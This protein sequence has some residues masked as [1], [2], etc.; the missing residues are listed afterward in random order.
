M[1]LDEKVF[2]EE[3]QKQRQRSREATKLVTGD[4]VQLRE[5]DKQEFVGYDLLETS[6]K[7]VR[8]R[9]VSSK[10]E[11]E[12]YQLVF[13]LTPFYPEGGGQVGDK[14]YLKAADGSITYI[15]DTK[16]EN[17][18]IIHFAKNLPRD[19]SLT[20]DAVVD[21]KQRAR[22]AAN[23]TATHLLHQA[24]RSVLGDHVTQKGSMVHSR[25]LRFDFSHFSKLTDEEL[26]EV[27]DFVNA[28]IREGISLEEKRNVPYDM[29]IEE[30]ALAF[31]GERYGDT[32][33][34]IRFGNSVELCGGTH[35][36]NTRDI[37]HFIITAETA[38]AAG[39]RRIEA[40]TSDAAKQYFVDRSH[41]LT[42]VQKSLNNPK[43]PVQ[44]LERI[45]EE[46]QQLQKQIEQLLKEKSR[47]IK[48]ELKNQ[49]Q[50]INGIQFLSKKIDLDAE[51]GRASCRKRG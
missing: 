40:I 31:F 19:V 20:F 30:G 7:I 26:K 27:E 50:T 45:Q 51:I 39:I 33:R 48:Q 32:V 10:R 22:T 13:N 36:G 47:N 23:H 24:L 15:V 35:V 17:N 2:E 34:I 14:G 21:S 1:K 16:I 49:V 12:L 11:G 41:T 18:L 4:W 3:L 43:D 9:K 38:V 5:D 46:N 44:A 6:V 42:A 29:A 8:Y 37:W 28:R 25:Y